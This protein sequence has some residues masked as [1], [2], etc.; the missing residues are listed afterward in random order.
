MKVLVDT[1]ILID[2]IAQHAPFFPASADVWE[3]AETKRIDGIVAAL[4]FTTVHYLIGKQFGHAMADSAVKSLFRVFAVAPV[5][6]VVII[7]SIATGRR[8]F[9]DAVQ[10]VA[11]LRVGSTHVVTRDPKGF[12]RTGLIVVA[13]AQLVAM[14]PSPPAQP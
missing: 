9:E 5:D 14:F 10:A 13:P 1:N 8:D 7:D 2:V 12:A 3:L 4:S 6:S 11:A